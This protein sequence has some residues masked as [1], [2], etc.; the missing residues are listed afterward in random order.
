M[1]KIIGIMQKIF[2]FMLGIYLINFISKFISKFI[3]ESMEY[4]INRNDQ[5]NL[6]FNSIYEE[7]YINKYGKK[8]DRKHDRFTKEDIEY[9]KIKIEE[10]EISDSIIMNRIKRLENE[11]NKNKLKWIIL[12]ALIGI[13]INIYKEISSTSFFIGIAIIILFD[14]FPNGYDEKTITLSYNN[15]KES[16]FLELILIKKYQYNEKM[17]EKIKNEQNPF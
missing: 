17:I 6:I 1:I 7:Y 15:A 8:F 4:L 9:L 12:S 14:M 10:K 5:L 13:Y 3:I 16:E 11:K 2:F